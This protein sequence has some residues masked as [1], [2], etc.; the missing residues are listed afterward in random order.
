MEKNWSKPKIYVEF[1]IFLFV[2]FCDW[3]VFPV[4]LQ[5]V[6]LRLKCSNVLLVISQDNTH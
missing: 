3:N 1:H 5:F 6:D 2:L 4:L